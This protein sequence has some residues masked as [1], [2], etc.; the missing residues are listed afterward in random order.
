MSVLPGNPEMML[1]SKEELH[2]MM[3]EF[4]DQ[5]AKE[6]ALHR[7]LDGIAASTDAFYLLFAGTIVFFMQ[8]GFAL[9]EAGNLRIKNVQNILF[10]NILDPCFGAIGFWAFGYG[11]AYGPIQSGVGADTNTFIGGQYFFLD[12]FSSDTTDFE[13]DD[14]YHSWFFQFAFAATTAT[15]VSGAVAERCKIEAYLAY[16][17]YICMFVYPVVVH[18]VWSSNGYLSAFN[19]DPMEGI[20]AVDFAGSG[21]VHMCGGVAALCASYVLG[22]RA[23]RWLE[24]GELNE[25]MTGH[26]PVLY[27]LGTMI[28]W[29]GWY[30]FNPGSTLGITASG[31]AFIAS[32]TATTTTLSAAFGGVSSALFHK[33]KTGKW[34]LSETCNGVLAGLVGITAGCS[35]VETWASSLIGII[36][37]FVYAFGDWILKKLHIDD[38]VNVIPVH[39]FCGAWGVFAVGLFASRTMVETVYG[40]SEAGL[41]YSGE[42]K[43]LGIQI[44]E[45]LVIFIWTAATTLP[46][47]FVLKKFN[48]FRIPD[49]IQ[50][51]G[52]DAYE[53]IKVS[54]SNLN[55]V[56]APSTS[57]VEMENTNPPSF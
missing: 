23:N 20:G 18:L 38:P 47:F 39:G 10:K 41:F 6:T 29:F 8:A 31:Y 2:Q 45:I 15:V 37:V 12:T 42:F 14:S 55:V 44:L 19:A 7:N 51:E 25:D 30:G 35:T 11:L 54:H 26:N 21:V 50:E 22:P 52:I 32:K 1:I 53:H 17:S 9:L 34:L 49:E 57:E 40:P 4:V 3:Q 24:N 5:S 43:M 56:I 16:S 27:V 28:L 36:S 46:F 33:F 13:T 48:L